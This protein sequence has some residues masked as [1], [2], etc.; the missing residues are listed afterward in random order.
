MPP[1]STYELIAL[2]EQLPVPAGADHARVI[3]TRRQVVLRMREIA[4]A[5]VRRPGLA[6]TILESASFGSV[7]SGF[8]AAFV[9]GE[10]FRREV[11]ETPTGGTPRRPRRARIV[12]RL[13]EVLL[14]RRDMNVVIDDDDLLE[15][16]VMDATT[17]E[18]SAD[19]ET[20][21]SQKLCERRCMNE[22]RWPA[23]RSPLVPGM[24]PPG[25]A[26]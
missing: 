5:S 24:Q 4:S 12:R 18:R 22:D 13:A 20:L 19:Y 25:F 9:Y 10:V 8:S 3:S 14:K 6:V 16:G 7:P 1:F 11:L 15:M 23:G 17:G 2:A 26:P 21:L